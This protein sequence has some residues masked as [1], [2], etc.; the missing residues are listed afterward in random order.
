[1]FW[2]S[3]LVV[4]L[5]GYAATAGAQQ[6]IF[7]VRHAEFIRSADGQDRPLTE[8]GHQ[9]AKALA[10][11]LKDTGINTIF[12]STLQPTIETAKPLAQ[13]L[14]LEPTAL[15][16]LTTKFKPSDVD[17]FVD[18]LR[19]RHRADI[20]LFVGHSNTVPALIKV[21]GH[22]NEIEIPAGEYDNLFVV[23]PKSEG[24]PI[25]LRLRF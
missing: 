25:V 22:P 17:A 7:V 16:Q 14:K 12:T 10:T 19:S 1:M 24:P 8:A 18:L 5:A 3:T 20:V 15:P 4:T 2:V 21:L 9:R 11:L 13:A 23:V 6:V